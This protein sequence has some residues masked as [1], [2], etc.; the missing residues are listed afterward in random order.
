LTTLRTRRF[1]TLL[2]KM[3]VMMVKIWSRY[4]EAASVGI[5]GYYLKWVQY[6]FINIGLYCF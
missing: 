4:D 6:K 5:Y 3:P 1:L 2:L